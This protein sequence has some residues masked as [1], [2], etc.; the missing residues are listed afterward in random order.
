MNELEA[1]AV[2]IGL[3]ALRCIAPLLITIGL[4]YL[5]NRLIDR[6][7]AEEVLAEREDALPVPVPQPQP[8]APGVVRQPALSIPCWLFQNCDESRRAR[9]AA[10]R[11]QGI[12]CWQAR[13]L[14]EGK[15]PDTCPSCPR[16]IAAQAAA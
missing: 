4:C 10:Y 7:E 11:R 1:T 9:C 14:E 6:W 15:L 16:Y 2:L 12:P 8:A 13:L 5:M 3:F